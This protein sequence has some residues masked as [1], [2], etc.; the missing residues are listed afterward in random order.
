MGLNELY[1][2]LEDTYYRFMDG[3]E[4]SGIKVYEW[5]INPLEDR[6]MPSMPFFFL[7]VLL[8]LGIGAFAAMSVL[9]GGFPPLGNSGAVNVAV[10]VTGPDSVNL[11]SILVRLSSGDD[12]LSA[13]TKNGVANFE[14]VPY[15]KK[16]TI[17]I[18][19][20]AGYNAFSKEF[21]LPSGKSS[22]T[23]SISL[24]AAGGSAGGS[25][26]LVLFVND[27]NQFPLSNA[28]VRFQ[29]P[30]T[31]EFVTRQ[32][33]AQ[34][35]VTL[36]VPPSS[37][38]V[39]LAVSH[40]GYESTTQSCLTSSSSCSVT[41][42]S[43]GGGGGGTVT[44]NPSVQPG[45]ATVRVE[46]LD[47]QGNG[48]SGLVTLY[49]NDNAETLDSSATDSQG[50]A[51]FDNVPLGVEV[52]ATFDPDSNDFSLHT[53]DS[54]V[55]ASDTDF[56]VQLPKKTTTGGGTDFSK[57]SLQAVDSAKSPIP[58]AQ[59]RLYLS[60]A[61]LRAVSDMTLT[62]DD[63]KVSFDIAPS[64][65][66]Y[67]T[68]WAEGY[69]PATTRVLT[70]GEFTQQVLDRVLVGNHGS[71]NVSVIDD[72][73]AAVSGATVTLQTHDGFPLGLPAQDTELDGAT[74]FGNLPLKRVKATAVYGA[75]SGQSDIVEIG[76]EP[77]SMRIMLQPATAFVSAKAF[78]AANR[79]AMSATFTAALSSTN[80][81]VGTCQSNGTACSIQVPANRNLVLYANASGYVG[82]SSEEF[83]VEPSATMHKSLY[84]LPSSLAN[85]LTV[86]SYAVL[87]ENGR[88]VTALDKG[89]IYSFAVSFNLPS[90]ARKAGVFLRVGTQADAAQSIATFGDYSQPS[91]AEIVKGGRFNPGP[92]CTDDLG[93]Q[94][95]PI[96]WIDWTYSSQFGAGT[97]AADVFVKPD[98]K[99]RDEVVLHYRLYAQAGEINLRKPEDP[100]F[101]GLEKTADLDSCYAQTVTIKLPVIDGKSDCND[102]AC[103]STRF[104][105][106][107]A[108]AANGLRVDAGSTFNVS[109]DLRAFE[110]LDA[111]R[112]SITTSPSVQITG[113]DFGTLTPV[114]PASTTV[115][116]P[117]SFFQRTNGTLFA[118]ALLPTA[119]SRFNLAF[120]DT[121]GAILDVNRFVVVQ[122]TGTFVI[123]PS[124][125]AIETLQDN[126][127]T[128]DVKSDRNVPVTDARLTLKET[129]GSPFDGFP[130]E[131]ITLQGDGSKDNGQDGIYKFK[132][133][134]P[135]APG[136]FAVVASRDGFQEGEAQVAA[137]ATEP[138]EFGSDISNVELDCK[139]P[140]TLTVSSRVNAE[141]K[142][143]A[144]FAGTAC[145]SMRVLSTT[146]TTTPPVHGASGSSSANFRVKPGK[147]TRILL[148]PT[149]DGECF[150]AFNAETVNG[151]ALGSSIAVLSS[152][153]GVSASPTPT[154]SPQ[155]GN[156]SPSPT[157]VPGADCAARGGQC[158]ALGQSCPNG[159][160]PSTYQPSSPTWPTGYTP[161]SNVP[162]Y[163]YG[164]S[165]YNTGLPPYF[166]E[167]PP[168]PYGTPTPTPSA[169]AAV[170]AEGQQCCIPVSQVCQAPNFNFQNI[171]SKYLGYYL[172]AQTLGNYPQQV[173][174]ASAPTQLTATQRGVALKKAGDGCTPSASGISCTKPIF[175]IVPYNA[176]AFSVEN[177]LF[178]TVDILTQYNNPCY[179][180]QE[181]GKFS[182]VNDI[183]TDIKQ[184]LQSQVGLLTRQTRTFVVTFR[185]RAQC[186]QYTAG[187][188]GQIKVEPIGKGKDGFQVKL[189][190]FGTGVNLDARDYIV[191]FAVQTAQSQ[192][193]HLAFIA[194]PSGAITLRGKTGL[195][196]EEPAVFA[197][198]IQSKQVQFILNGA[199]LTNF[200]VAG[201]DARATT[202]T[203]KKDDKLTLKSGATATTAT[204]LPLQVTIQPAPVGL[205]QYD[206]VGNV[207]ASEG[208]YSCSG[209]NYCTPEQATAYLETV[210]TALNAFAVQY[211][212]SVDTL[213]YEDPL[214]LNGGD[215]QAY[216]RLYQQAMQDALREYMA[217]R[218]Q[219]E[220]CIRQGQDPLAQTRQQCQQSGIA[221]IYGYN[222]NTPGY[223]DQQGFSGGYNPYG[224]PYGGANPYGGGISGGAAVNPALGGGQVPYNPYQSNFYPGQGYYPGYVNDPTIQQSFGDAFG[225]GWQQAGCHSDILNAFQYQGQLNTGYFNPFMQQQQQWY[226]YS[227]GVYS[228]RKPVI[229]DLQPVIALP[230]KEAGNSGGIKVYQIKADLTGASQTGDNVEFERFDRMSSTP[231]QYDPRLWTQA[232]DA[233]S[234][235][236]P[237]GS[238]TLKEE[239]RGFPY[240]KLSAD[241]KKYE[242]QNWVPKGATTTQS[243]APV[244]TQAQELSHA[245]KATRDDSTCSSESI[246]GCRGQKADMSFTCS[247][248][249]DRSQSGNGKCGPNLDLL[250]PPGKT[251]GSDGKVIC[252]CIASSS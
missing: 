26:S 238:Q 84:L 80:R 129:Q 192:A 18:D 152:Q 128:V 58:G 87:D 249:S 211:L 131:P 64:A 45:S 55:T 214:G 145:A 9:G 52:Y 202:L 241:G 223:Y 138:L 237:K 141:L 38:A 217:L 6:G 24:E 246:G 165:P 42:Y 102:R 21:P 10:K 177:Q 99:P 215:G 142:V 178:N 31:G 120:S 88:N 104:Y 198:N 161:Y 108:S 224:S 208:A 75:Q 164:P 86:L 7:G 140:T 201:T 186:V 187:Q 101:G 250:T 185:P 149:T 92:S 135:H 68:V 72:T 235:N 204:E 121:P 175:P 54:K 251:P 195:S 199:G 70:G 182:G 190:P 78:D 143:A 191:H 244:S 89:R 11:E 234:A 207:G 4:N 248:A 245:P 222:Q 137:N 12:E 49:R 5:F 122:G 28:E 151:Q 34:G 133:L 226:G 118:K 173:T 139:N 30:L 98:A 47:L 1:Q 13:K 203:L 25:G 169:T 83:S 153:C 130:N 113:Y 94:N 103:L 132:K 33:D 134:R 170:C 123:V 59:V 112:L 35:R 210:K 240:L 125:T 205:D 22:A 115:S 197:N 39:T 66:V 109:I 27:D 93:D 155:P 228:N 219:Y 225:Q 157:P 107:T 166:S 50:V 160:I 114:S 176:L 14:S 163:P 209:A 189:K 67:A 40:D 61:A 19:A 62:D 44:P 179:E 100:R 74:V 154:V 77:K 239:Y 167:N 71:L 193:D 111:P 17:R 16:I 110:A 76:L 229:A 156:A 242:I 2:S 196:F 119:S 127:L 96:Q 218:S 65:R 53:F 181:V 180:I 212:A 48:L 37:P 188:D 82:L 3:L 148:T 85:Q 159:F 206:I 56:F 23:F 95:G 57:V 200:V 183:F 232:S 184:N 51:R 43:S 162:G 79:S 124:P 116:I 220:A 8:I 213:A 168:N 227:R 158:V 15:S 20:A 36:S 32:T 117:L 194:M 63:G 91:A 136:L 146:A 216:Q 105:S 236:R 29:D 221:P 41:L 231:A 106:A 150:L 243:N 90:N 172:G 247:M 252:R 81:V 126:T 46:V 144:S 69:L 73:G 233:P 174:A 230:V 171:F 147:D 60:G 97:V